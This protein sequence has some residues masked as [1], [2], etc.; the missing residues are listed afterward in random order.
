MDAIIAEME[1]LFRKGVFQKRTSFRF[2]VDDAS[3]TVTIDPESF[4]VE[5][6]TQTGSVDC[7]CSVFA[8]SKIAG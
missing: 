4:S 3:M 2:T 7:S 6:G 1:S 8:W 5:M